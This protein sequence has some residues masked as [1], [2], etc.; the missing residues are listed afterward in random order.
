MSAKIR[1]GI[2]YGGKS[3][4]HEVSIRSAESIVRELTKDKYEV[5][6]I[7][8]DK[9]G[10]FDLEKLKNVDVVFPIVHGTFGEDGTL[11]GMFE[12]L[13][14]AYVGAGVLGSAIAMDKDI[15]KRLFLQAKIPICKYVIYPEKHKFAYP[16][17]VK[18]ANMGSSVGVSKCKNLQEE[19]QAVKEALKYD[20]KVLIEENIVGREI[21]V[22]VLGNDKPIASLPGEIKPMH[23]FYDYE[24]KYVDENGAKTEI[25]AKL[26]DSQIKKIQRLAIEAYKTLECKGMAR[27]DMFLSASGKVFLNEINTLPGFTSISMYPKLWQATGITY[28]NLLDKLIRLALEEKERKDKLQRSYE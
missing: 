15:M 13:D 4:E 11:Q 22:S 27:V 9:Q 3:G 8:I 24:A 23:E 19:V 17:F 5:V 20:A 14:L 6:D 26:S 18:P 21:E 12:I 2:V 1:V 16:V 28:P 10:K 25:P 7:F